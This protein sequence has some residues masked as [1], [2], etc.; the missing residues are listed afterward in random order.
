MFLNFYSGMGSLSD[1]V[2]YRNGKDSLSQVG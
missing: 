2:L 1:L